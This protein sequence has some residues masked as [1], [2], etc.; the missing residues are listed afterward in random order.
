MAVQT[1]ESADP[2]PAE[3]D[4]TES[5]KRSLIMDAA[6]N[7][8]LLMG[9]WML[10]NLVR[11]SAGD[12]LSAAMANSTSLLHLQDVLGLPNEASIQSRFLE[13]TRMIRAA[14]LYYMAA[15][16]PVTIT[17]LVWAWVRHRPQFPLVR[18]TL[19][20]VTAIGLGLHVLY[21]LVPPRKLPS[22]IDTGLTF[23]PSPYEHAASEAA[24][25]LAAMPSLHVGWA[26]LVALSIIAVTTSRLRFLALVHPMVTT[27][28]VVVTANHYWADAIVAAVI[29]GLAWIIMRRRE[30]WLA[31]QSAQIKSIL[32][33]PDLFEHQ[34]LDLR[35][36]ARHELSARHHL[37][38]M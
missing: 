29:V 34:T 7:F 23:G 35:R 6:R 28:V 21:P 13:H 24:N 17:F 37:L 38:D 22:F 16:F 14:N 36:S 30:Q 9:L 8:L 4:H 18:N 10:Y 33:A 2:Q 26:L 25:Q 3:H 19:I 15:H 20:T 12:E 11:L 32:T 5:T 27:V 31:T 1:C